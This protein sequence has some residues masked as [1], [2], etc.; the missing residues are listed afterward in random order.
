MHFRCLQVLLWRTI[1]AKFDKTSF[2]HFSHDKRTE[3]SNATERS[4]GADFFF[5]FPHGLKW[6]KSTVA[7]THLSCI[8][9]GLHHYLQTVT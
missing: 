6:L 2:R 5:F 7:Y 8:I 4:E 1:W 3:Y 9:K